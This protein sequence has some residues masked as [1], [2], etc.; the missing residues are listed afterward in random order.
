[1][2]KILDFKPTQ[3][4]FGQ[5]EVDY[6]VEKIKKMNHEELRDYL[7]DRKVPIVSGPG[8]Q[9]YLVDHHHLVRSCWESGIKEV[10]TQDLADLTQLSVKEFWEE[11]IKSHWVYPYD[12]IGNGPHDIVLLPQ[13][14]RGMADDPFR[15]LAWMAREAGAFQKSETPFAEFKWAA[16][17]RKNL[18][19]HPVTEGF[20][21]CLKEVLLLSKEPSA[22]HLPGYQS[23]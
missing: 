1:M 7:H 10:P 14:I 13:D 20:P 6:R 11:M 2:I 4:V 8:K 16:F 9:T 3:M 22:K 15:S 18:K 21:A 17:Y 19:G 23:K 5:K 12:Q